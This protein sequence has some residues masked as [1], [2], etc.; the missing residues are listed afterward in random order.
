MGP[1]YYVQFNL[2]LGFNE[3]PLLD[4]ENLDYDTYP[5]S[6]FKADIYR[7][8]I[9]NDEYANHTWL[10]LKDG[11]PMAGVNYTEN[12]KHALYAEYANVV[13]DF[14]KHYSRDQVTKEI[15]YDPYVR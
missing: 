6:G 4:T 15:I 1:R 9:L 2:A 11:V 12:N 10:F 13:W 14:C 7:K 8:V 5:I 3:M